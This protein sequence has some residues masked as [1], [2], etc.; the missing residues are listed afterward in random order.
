MS[1]ES[2][3]GKTVVPGTIV[4]M[5]DFSVAEADANYRALY[6]VSNA[7]QPSTFSEIVDERS[8]R[9]WL[10]VEELLSDSPN[11]V[12]RE[13]HIRSLHFGTSIQISPEGKIVIASHTWNA[14]N[15]TVRL[16]YADTG[17]FYKGRT[18]KD[19]NL[20]S[21]L[22][23]FSL[24]K[25]APAGISRALPVQDLMRINDATCSFVA[26]DKGNIYL[27]GDNRLF[28]TSFRTP[29]HLDELPC[30]SGSVYDKIKK[31]SFRIIFED[32]ALG[33]CLLRLKRREVFPNGPYFIIGH[34]WRLEDMLSSNAV[35]EIHPE[36]SPQ[37]AAA[38][39]AL[40][41]GL[42]IKEAAATLKKSPVT[43][44]LQARSALR[45]TQERTLQAL[46]AKVTL[47]TA[48]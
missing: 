27:Q 24:L 5:H 37:E 21:I 13:Q 8:S 39:A 43:V 32:P 2:K 14:A 22:W 6:S 33:Q 20:K 15:A 12:I 36:F 18:I 48:N 44:A 16:T 38:I 19:D 11:H 1:R 17:Y 34:I 3:N 29:R 4:L 7:F 25:E 46:I 26:D 10:S 40:V 42:T 9:G 30:V 35:M 31:G 41:R 47:S 23:L 28:T 45:K